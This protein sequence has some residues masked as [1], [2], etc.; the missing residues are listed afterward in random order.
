MIQIPFKIARSRNIGF[1]QLRATPVEAVYVFFVEASNPCVDQAC[2]KELAQTLMCRPP[3]FFEPERSN[4]GGREKAH[5]P[6]R[7]E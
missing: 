7:F 1:R 2:V 6:K 4:L 3:A 5:L